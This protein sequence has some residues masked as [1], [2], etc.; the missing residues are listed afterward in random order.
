MSTN[1]FKAGIPWYL[2][3]GTKLVLAR[4][5][6]PYR[7]WKKIG[8]FDNGPMQKSAYALQVFKLHFQ[9]GKVSPGFTC[10]ELGPGD[11]LLS[12]LFA[13]AHGAG[14]TYLIDAGS[15]AMT[16]CEVYRQVA[17]ELKSAGYAVP[18]EFGSVEEMLQLCRAEYLTTGLNAVEMI[19]ARSVDFIWSQ[20]V[21]EHVRKEEFAP[22]ITAWRR[23]IK[24]DGFASHSV[25]LKDH[26][27]SALNNLRFS[28]ERWE[29]KLFRTS[30]FYTNRIRFNEM[31]EIFRR[32]GFHADVTARKRWETLP[33][34]RHKLAPRF[35]GCSDEELLTSSFTVVLRPSLVSDPAPSQ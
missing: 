4:L 13:C 6:L 20:A 17:V 10:L 12:A 35:Q 16:D 27:N 19:P 32:H 23:V 14:K 29:S 25:D 22:M 30:G 5:P 15:F 2:K 7:L 24:D 28:D 31:L 26:F 11:S 21:L 9:A 34:P 8:I 1:N 18:T 3:I 33:T